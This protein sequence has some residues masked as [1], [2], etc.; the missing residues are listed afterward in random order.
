MGQ[1]EFSAVGLGRRRR[2][3]DWVAG[4]IGERAGQ[5]RE[6]IRAVAVFHAQ[7][8]N[9]AAP[10]RKRWAKV[11]LRVDARASADGPQERA[12]VVVNNS[13]L[14]TFVIDR[15]GPDPEDPDWD[16]VRVVEYVLASVTLTAA[17]VRE[18][19]PG[20]R[21]LDIERVRELRRIKNAVGSFP[22]LVRHLPA[23]ALRDQAVEWL[24][25]REVLP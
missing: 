18:L 2:K 16:P 25:I 3:E 9:L 6:H 20:W 22:L 5:K 12:R 7:D 14:R 15:L 21:R 19:G 4:E 10:L 11:A 8:D 23:G 1:D 13:S 24:V 17:R